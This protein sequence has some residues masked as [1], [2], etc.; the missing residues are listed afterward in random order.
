MES[1]GMDVYAIGIKQIYMNLDLIFKWLRIET[2]YWT[3][4]IILFF[5]LQTMIE[6]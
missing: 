3:H 2:V 5:F 4:F 6:L 1:W